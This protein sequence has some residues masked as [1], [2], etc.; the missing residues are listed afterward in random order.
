MRVKEKLYWI[1]EERYMLPKKKERARKERIVAVLLKIWR[2]SI[3]PGE[4]IV[5]SD[6]LGEKEGFFGGLLCSF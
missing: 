1:F 6:I 3:W 5:G 4:R 2:N